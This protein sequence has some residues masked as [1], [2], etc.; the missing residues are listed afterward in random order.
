MM[1]GLYY[2][3]PR[4]HLVCPPFMRSEGIYVC[5]RLPFGFN[6]PSSGSRWC[7][8]VAGGQGAMGRRN[9]EVGQTKQVRG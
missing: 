6:I 9:G 4:K 3:L 2:S 1:P 5:I 7:I 8:R